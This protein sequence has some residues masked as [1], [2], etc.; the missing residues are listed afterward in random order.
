MASLSGAKAE[1]GGTRVVPTSRERGD[2]GFRREP[3][4]V[5][6]GVSK[7][8]LG[9]PWRMR[10]PPDPRVEGKEQS[11]AVDAVGPVGPVGRRPAERAPN[12]QARRKQFLLH[13]L[14]DR[15]ETS[16]GK[17]K[18]SERRHTLYL[19]IKM[20]IRALFKKRNRM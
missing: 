4:S 15:Q 8:T 14:A 10:F 17:S 6:G 13:F 19:K 5:T 18:M 12:A 20:V 3:S 7:R 2:W 9:R 16:S 1:W 11:E